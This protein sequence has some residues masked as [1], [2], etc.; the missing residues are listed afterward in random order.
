MS[1]LG[2]V[3]FLVLF[4]QWSLAVAS[5]FELIVLCACC[6]CALGAVP[7]GADLTAFCSGSLAV[8]YACAL[9][10]VPFGADSTALTSGSPM[11]ISSWYAC[12]C[13]QLHMFCKLFEISTTNWHC[14]C[15]WSGTELGLIQQQSL[16]TA[17]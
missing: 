8:Q 15:C 16:V 10:A 4:Q 11:T 6:V 3:P 5:R 13:T 9:D 14:E 12:M 2:T 1:A 7:F 17:L